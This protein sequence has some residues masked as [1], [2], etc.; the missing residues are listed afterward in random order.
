MMR[1]L[2]NVI[3]CFLVFLHKYKMRA[4]SW[5]VFWNGLLIPD[6][7][8]VLWKMVGALQHLSSFG[9]VHA[10][11]RPDYITV[12]DRRQQPAR[13]PPVGFSPSDR[14]HAFFQAQDCRTLLL[15]VH[16]ITEA[17]DL[18]ANGG[19]SAETE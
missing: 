13:V 17:I 8:S 6:S 10:D 19:T 14:L 4:L 12:V 18:L 7:K 16:H 9:I 3:R 11:V 1:R 5:K 2:L 15:G